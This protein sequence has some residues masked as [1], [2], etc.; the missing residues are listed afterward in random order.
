MDYY[1]TTSTMDPAAE[2]V[3]AGIGAGTLIVSAIISIF[4][5]ITIWKLFQKAGQPGWAAIIP[6]YNIVVM[7]RV[8]KMDWWHI[9]IMLFVPFAAL[10]YSFI[11]PF[12][13]AQV[14]GKSAGF[15]VL[16]IFLPIIAYPI[17]AF[18]DAQYQG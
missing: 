17:M 10:V 12:K 1:T 11:I 6:I 8:I 15:G 2:G 7:F 4:M 5:L 14:F 13:L 9:L 16:A 18:G 3:L